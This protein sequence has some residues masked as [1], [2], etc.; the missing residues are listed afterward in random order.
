MNTTAITPSR[1]WINRTKRHLVLAA[2]AIAAAWLAY[3]AVPGHDTRHRLSMGTAYSAL[4]LLVVCLA[5]GPWK[6][7]R[8]QPNPVSF[9]L[10]RDTGIWAGVFALLHT[11][12]GLTVHLRG[13]MWMYF[14]SHL[15][16]LKI[17]AS[18][19]GLANYVGA[20]AALLFLG[21]LTISNDA[22]LRSMKARRWKSLQRWTYA[23]A[24]LTVLHGALFQSVEGRPAPWLAAYWALVLAAASFQ[25]AG[26]LARK[27]R[28]R[29]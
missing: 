5:L 4:A 1:Y 11:A 14:F 26:Y 13:R 16:P 23:A 20:V 9:D 21:L 12:V 24:V 22:S 25:L 27:K 28:S 17:Q 3:L 19:F 29:G 2:C 7:L 10:R 8:R 15:H 18:K 6:V